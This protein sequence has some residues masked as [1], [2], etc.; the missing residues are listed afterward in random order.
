MKLSHYTTLL[1]QRV[2]ISRRA[3]ISQTNSTLKDHLM[4]VLSLAERK[5]VPQVALEHGALGVLLDGLEHLL[6]DLL[7][8][9]L[10][11]LGSLVLHLLGFEDVAVLLDGLL[12]RPG[13]TEVAIVDLFRDLDGGDV[14]GGGSGNQIARVDATKRAAIDLEGA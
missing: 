7:L 13:S 14:E 1:E 10:A 3:C 11:L 5:V 2:R 6:V 8:V 12:G 4:W 9:L